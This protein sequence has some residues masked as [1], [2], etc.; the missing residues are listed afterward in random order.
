[1][2]FFFFF[3]CAESWLQHLDFSSCSMGLVSY[4]VPC[5]ILVPQPGID[6]ESP[7]LEGEFLTTGPPGKSGTSIAFVAIEVD[8]ADLWK[9]K[10][11]QDIG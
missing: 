3:G 11:F 6:P 8:E 2:A 1:M 5:G 10:D 7:G 9:D 4:P